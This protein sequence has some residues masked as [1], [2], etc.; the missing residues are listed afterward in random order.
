MTPGEIEERAR[1]ILLDTDET[2]P[3]FE[4]K[5]LFFAM[6]DGMVQTRSVRPES[7]YHDGVLV[8][9]DFPMPTDWD[10]ISVATASEADLKMDDR[11]L[12]AI[13][14]YVVHRMYMKDDPDTQNAN[15]AKNYLDLYTASVQT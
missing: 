15:L 2:A 11:W 4:A 8:D 9:L 1:I 7:R 5:E 3:R 14:Y 12:E 13:V 6:R 10:D